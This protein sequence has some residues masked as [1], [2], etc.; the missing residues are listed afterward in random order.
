MVYWPKI[1]VVK[2]ILLCIAPGIF[3]QDEQTGE[4][5]IE[6]SGIRNEKGDMKISL[7]DRADPFPGDHEQAV[8]RIITEI[9]GPTASAVFK[10]IPYG[11][12]AVSVMHDENNNF[13]LDSNWLGIPREGYGASNNP[14]RRMGPPRYDDARF[15]LR[16]PRMSLTI[17]M[18]Y[19]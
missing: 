12:Y 15:S 5:Q 19:F 4:I 2:I 9:E 6:I 13:I 7:F 1:V 16:Q 14:P 18:V 8:G 17:K 10:S 3:S 11:E